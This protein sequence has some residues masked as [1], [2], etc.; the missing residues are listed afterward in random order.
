MRQALRTLAV[1]RPRICLRALLS[2]ARSAGNGAKARPLRPISAVALSTVAVLAGVAGKT[3]W[4]Q[5]A[6]AGAAPSADRADRSTTPLQAAPVP[7]YASD[8]DFAVALG[9]FA[10]IVGSDN[11]TSSPD[12]TVAHADSFYSTHHPPDPARQKPGVVIYP[13]DTDQVSRILKVAHQYRVPVVANSG[14]T[15]L[16]GHNM[17]TRGPNSVSLAFGNLND[18]VEFHPDDMDIVVQA[19]VGWQELDEYLTSREDGKH[20]MFG[21]DPGMGATIAG[22]VGTSASGTNAYRYGTMKENVVNLTVV[23]ADG[24]VVKTR[25]R[26]RKSSAGYDLTHVFIGSEGTLGVVTE[27]TLKLHPRPFRELVCIAAFPT[28]KNAAAAAQQ[29]ITKSGIQANALELVNETTMSFVND[30]GVLDKK[31]L[32]KPSL[33]LKLGG[34]SDDVVRQQTDI[35]KAVAAQHNSV[36][37]ELSQDPTNNAVLWGARRAALWSTFEYGKKVLDDPNDVQIWTTD[38]AVPISRLTTLIDGANADLIASGFRN[39]F[40]VMGHVGDGNCHFLLLYNSKDYAKAKEV[41]DRIVQR[42]IDLDGTCTGEHGVGVGKRGYLEAELGVEAVDLMR[43]L[44]YSLDPRAILN[45]DKVVK[46]DPSDNLDE[47]LH[48]GHVVETPKCC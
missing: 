37:F 46:I 1:A 29:I 4:D 22:M 2:T 27:I 23:L 13:A 24:T 20:L 14:L 39:R 28:I 7:Q 25:R 12:V 33:L 26:P 10:E 32:E 34:P 18:V 41:V 40:S 47:L 30:S 9:K 42:T 44:K 15:S 17:H 8:A 36:H 21:P 31:F 38:F 5:Q 6:D 3:W 16:E 45:P 19:G 35:V 48:S 43:H 11:I